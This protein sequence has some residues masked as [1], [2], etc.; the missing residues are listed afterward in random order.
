MNFLF[1]LKSEMIKELF[2]SFLNW[3]S[4]RIKESDN[5][6]NIDD[7]DTDDYYI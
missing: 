6:D 3:K 2:I 4:E 7:T 5:I 1:K